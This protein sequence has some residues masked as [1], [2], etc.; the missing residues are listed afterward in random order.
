MQLKSIYMTHPHPTKKRE[1]NRQQLWKWCE[2]WDQRELSPNTSCKNKKQKE[3]QIRKMHLLQFECSRGMKRGE[4]GTACLP[5]FVIYAHSQETIR[6]FGCSINAVSSAVCVNDVFPAPPPHVYHSF[7]L[8]ACFISFSV[9]VF[10][11]LF[12]SSFCFVC[13]VL[14]FLCFN[15]CFLVSCH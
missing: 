9:F 15:N 11:F 12:F 8:S 3:Q 6:Y 2:N 1:R 14:C 13:D 10:Y 4:L 7:S 5:A